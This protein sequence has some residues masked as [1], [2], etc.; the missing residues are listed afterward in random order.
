MATY[1]TNAA[2]ART[3]TGLT[4][5]ELPDADYTTFSTRAQKRL[6][7]DTGYSTGG[8]SSSS[9]K[10]DMVQEAEAY[11]IAHMAVAMRQYGTNEESEEDIDT[12]TGKPSS[13]FLKEYYQLV[14]IINEK[15]KTYRVR[16]Q[17]GFTRVEAD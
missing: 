13:K 17:M 8:W 7:I 15:D 2:Q 11:M 14:A 5:V 3:I 10:Y 4:T 6:D 1:T 9:Q 16:N 12:G